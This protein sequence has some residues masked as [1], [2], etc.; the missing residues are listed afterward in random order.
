MAGGESR[1]AEILQLS[2]SDPSDSGQWTLIAPLSS[3]YFDTFL[4]EWRDHIFAIG[5][6]LACTTSF[7][8]KDSLLHLLCL[9]DAFR[10][11]NELTTSAPGQLTVRAIS[12]S[13]K[14]LFVLFCLS[15]LF[16]FSRRWRLLNRLLGGLWRDCGMGQLTYLCYVENEPFTFFQAS[17]LFLLALYAFN[18]NKNIISVYNL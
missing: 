13:R 7:F 4:V 8:S 14:P 3:L 15:F 1:T 12:R 5:S 6:S 9:L 2:C 16:F 18:H 17:I 11:V 10:K